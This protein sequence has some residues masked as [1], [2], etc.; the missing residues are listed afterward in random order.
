MSDTHSV[1]E[2]AIDTADAP[3]VKPRIGPYRRHLLLCTGPRCTVDGEAEALFNSLGERL[4][5]AD[6]TTGELRVKRTRTGCF[7]A[8]KGGPILCVQPDGAWY[9]N[10]TADNM[11]RII[12][13]HLLGG[14][15]VQSLLFH[16][17][18]DVTV[19]DAD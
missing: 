17:G 16:Q 9:Y 13:E 19:D 12:D 3:V 8:C 2:A 15:P 7:A 5:A 10:V 6:L 4:E 11:Q 1:A 14:R 18:P